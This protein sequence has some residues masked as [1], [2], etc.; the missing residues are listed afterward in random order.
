MCCLIFFGSMNIVHS[1]YTNPIIVTLCTEDTF[2][3][4]SPLGIVSYM[5]GILCCT[6]FILVMFWYPYPDSYT[7]KFPS[8]WPPAPAHDFTSRLDSLFPI[9]GFSFSRTLLF[10]NAIPKNT[11][12][13]QKPVDIP[14]RNTDTEY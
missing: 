4:I 10:R 11:D 1:Y 7:G 3:F 9:F 5:P 6:L 8:F 12:R 2:K 14:Y 13:L